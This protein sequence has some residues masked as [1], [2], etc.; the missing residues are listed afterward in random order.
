[1]MYFHTC[2][3]FVNMQFNNEYRILIKNVVARLNLPTAI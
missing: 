2:L 1:M 3:L